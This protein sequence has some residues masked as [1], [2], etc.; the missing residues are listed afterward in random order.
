MTYVGNRPDFSHVAPLDK[1]FVSILQT[2]DDEM[3]Q[4]IRDKYGL[5]L[6][7]SVLVIGISLMMLDLYRGTATHPIF[8]ILTFISWFGVA[9]GKVCR[10]YWPT[11]EDIDSNGNSK[12]SDLDK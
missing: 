12:E 6:D 3:L 2:L 9:L 7:L 5:A 10:S 4:T 1:P 11:D 8:I